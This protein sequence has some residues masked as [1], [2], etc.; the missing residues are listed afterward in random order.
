MQRAARRARG[1]ARTYILLYALAAAVAAC[2]P[3]AAA[4]EDRLMIP[5][6]PEIGIARHYEIVRSRQRSDGQRLERILEARSRAVLTPLSR[7]PAGYLYRFVIMET[8]ATAPGSTK[9]GLERL[10]SRLAALTTG[11]PLVYQADVR[12]MPRRLVNTREVRQALRGMLSE[13]QGLVR[14]LTQASIISQVERPN[15][16][17]NVRN[18]LGTLATLSD[19]ELSRN[20]LKEA[21]LLFAAGGHDLAIGRLEA[22]A[23]D[24]G[25]TGTAKVMSAEGRRGITSLDEAKRQAVV[26]VRIAYD[27]AQIGAAI[28]QLAERLIGDSATEKPR[29]PDPGS[30]GPDSFRVTESSRYLVDLDNGQPIALRHQRTMAFGARRLVEVTRIGRVGP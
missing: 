26:E 3:G 30:P 2:R 12:G 24:P 20:V 17:A 19:E 27:Q 11:V 28:A 1:P 8:K 6:A 4:A 10:L 21:G 18:I 15:M 25:A 16:E 14:S 13:L 22:F 7:N 5:F 23:P 29:T 9:P